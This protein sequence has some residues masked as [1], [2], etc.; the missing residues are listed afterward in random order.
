[1][2]GRKTSPPGKP[3]ETKQKVSKFSGKKDNPNGKSK[4]SHIFRGL[5][6]GKTGQ[7]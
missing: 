7:H 6:G 1:M 3:A 4:Y 5:V 2:N